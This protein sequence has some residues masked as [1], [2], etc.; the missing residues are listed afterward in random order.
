MTTKI[1]S[2]ISLF[3]SEAGLYWEELG[4]EQQTYVRELLAA[5]LVEEDG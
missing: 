4:E 2:I 1:D 3:Q 5:I